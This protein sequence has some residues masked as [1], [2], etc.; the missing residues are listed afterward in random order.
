MK[1]ENDLSFYLQAPIKGHINIHPTSF[2]P[3]NSFAAVPNARKY[4]MTA[5]YRSSQFDL[6]HQPIK[7]SRKNLKLSIGEKTHVNIV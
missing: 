6:L 4:K 5:Y 2:K 1:F 7:L 3:D